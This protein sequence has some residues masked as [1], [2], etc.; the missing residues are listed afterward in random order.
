MTLPRASRSLC[1]R[2]GRSRWAPRSPAPAPAPVALASGHLTAWR[3]HRGLSEGWRL[4]GC[5]GADVGVTAPVS[6]VRPGLE[7]GLQPDRGLLTTGT[8]P[9]AQSLN[10]RPICLCAGQASSHSAGAVWPGREELAA[11]ALA[12]WAPTCSGPGYGPSAGRGGPSVVKGPRSPLGSLPDP[13][14]SGACISA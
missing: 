7:S 9:A 5:A 8:A 1:C 2:S 6:T 10:L 3:A 4:E 13:P 12:L 14:S 11:P